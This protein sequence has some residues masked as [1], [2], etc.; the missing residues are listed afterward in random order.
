MVT[1]QTDRQ[2]LI[3][4]SNGIKRFLQNPQIRAEMTRLD[5]KLVDELKERVS[6]VDS[7]KGWL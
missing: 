5:P 1:E 2:K 7:L 4:L 6:D 3:S